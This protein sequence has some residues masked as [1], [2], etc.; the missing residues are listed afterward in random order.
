MRITRLSPVTPT[1]SPLEFLLFASASKTN[2]QPTLPPFNKIQ[3]IKQ[4]I[5]KFH[6][7]NKYVDLTRIWKLDED[8]YLIRLDNIFP[9]IYVTK[10]T[11]QQAI[12]LEI[13]QIPLSPYFT[14]SPSDLDKETLRISTVF[15]KFPEVVSFVFEVQSGVTLNHISPRRAYISQLKIIDIL[16]THAPL[17]PKSTRTALKSYHAILKD[18]SSDNENANPEGLPKVYIFCLRLSIFKFQ[19]T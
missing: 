15:T 12:H 2:W 19:V 13:S 7:C 16:L 9:T 6:K 17:I 5:I 3:Q 10:C 8:C 11:L 4:L 14:S 18:Q 1:L